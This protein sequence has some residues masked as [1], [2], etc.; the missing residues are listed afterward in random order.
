MSSVHSPRYKGLLKRLREA[1]RQAGLTQTEA[2]HAVAR[3][4]SFV[5]K[6]ESGERR[7]DVLELLD[8]AGVYGKSLGFFAAEAEGAKGASM[9][10]G[11]RRGVRVPAPGPT[12][13]RPYLRRR[14][15]PAGCCRHPGPASRR[16]EEGAALAPSRWS[17]RICRRPRPPSTKIHLTL[18]VG[19]RSI[20][21]MG[22]ND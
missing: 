1:R 21:S 20:L 18:E 2:A 16:L 13:P 10:V 5:S 15:A 22:T 3:P 11:A 19:P 17:I 8:L 9:D 7:I 12:P 6:C 14:S 4:Q